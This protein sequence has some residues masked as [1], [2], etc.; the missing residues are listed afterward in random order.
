MIV[1]SKLLKLIP[2]VQSKIA[3]EPRQIFADVNTVDTVGPGVISNEPAALVTAAIQGATGFELTVQV[4]VPN[5]PVK[6]AAG[7][8]KV[9][10]TPV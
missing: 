5:P 4:Y 9:L 1:T 10:V 8:V 7:K 6:S 2:S 3:S